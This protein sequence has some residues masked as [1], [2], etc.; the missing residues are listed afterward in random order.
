M[1]VHLAPKATWPVLRNIIECSAKQLSLQTTTI[2]QSLDAEDSV[3]QLLEDPS[4]RIL[5]YP[6]VI[7]TSEA[8][9]PE[10]EHGVDVIKVSCLF[11]CV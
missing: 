5:R 9:V 1:Q 8:R 7:M 6:R 11:F 3:Q 10:L 2:D 4:C